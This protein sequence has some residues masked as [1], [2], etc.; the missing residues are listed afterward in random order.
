MSPEKNNYLVV[1]KKV[2]CY[3][4]SV[5]FLARVKCLASFLTGLG[6]VGGVKVIICNGKS[7]AVLPMARE[8]GHGHGR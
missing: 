4:I 2:A 1:G 3:L 7:D 6:G 5:Y 8:T